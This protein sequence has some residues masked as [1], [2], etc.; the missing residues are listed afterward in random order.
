MLR[1]YTIFD[2]PLDIL[3]NKKT[4]INTINAYSYVMTKK[5]FLFKAGDK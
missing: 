5:D 3:E 4:L 1:E 2:K